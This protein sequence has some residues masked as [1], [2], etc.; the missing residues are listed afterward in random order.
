MWLAAPG[1][2]GD[3]ATLAQPGA[4]P[5]VVVGAAVGIQRPGLAP[6]PARSRDILLGLLGLLGPI[7]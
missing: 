2:L 7:H 1:D 3:G 4:A 5:D 6:G